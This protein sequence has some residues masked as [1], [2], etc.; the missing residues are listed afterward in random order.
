MW[1]ILTRLNAVMTT[2]MTVLAAM[3]MMLALSTGYFE[4]CSG[5]DEPIVI[6][7]DPSVLKM[8]HNP[9]TRND[10]APTGV[11]VKVDFR[12]IWHW[13]VKQIFLYVTASWET[14]GKLHEMFLYDHT[15]RE[16]GEF[17][18]G[19]DRPIFDYKLS[20]P[21]GQLRYL[22]VNLTKRVNDGVA[23]RVLFCATF[24]YFLL[25]WGHRPHQMTRLGVQN[26][27][28]EGGYQYKKKRQWRLHNC[29]N[30]TEA[31]TLLQQFTK[32]KF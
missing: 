32:K 30:T 27:S 29:G 4:Y 2:A 25:F 5:M 3:T 12:P 24:C 17:A 31:T 23:E 16:A 11:S 13:N 28:S 6:L 7:E 22:F 19:Q 9:Q 26:R 8:W 18:R 15:I 1:P 10:E 21:K 14:E 20:A